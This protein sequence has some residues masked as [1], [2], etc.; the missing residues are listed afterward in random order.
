MNYILPVN[1]LEILIPNSYDLA[2]KIQ[3]ETKTLWRSQWL[4]LDADILCPWYSVQ[5]ASALLMEQLLRADAGSLNHL[6]THSLSHMMVDA[7][8]RLGPQWGCQSEQL[9]GPFHTT[10]SQT[11]LGFFKAWQLGSKSEHSERAEWRV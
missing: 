10:L 3:K 8:C 9:W 6:K 4:Q 2:I 11:K 1:P 7:G 5:E